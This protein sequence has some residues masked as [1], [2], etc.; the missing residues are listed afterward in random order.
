MTKQHSNLMKLLVA[1]CL[2]LLFFSCRLWGEQ[3]TIPDSERIFIFEHPTNLREPDAK[4]VR[5]KDEKRANGGNLVFVA[6]MPKSWNPKSDKEARSSGKPSARGIIAFSSHDTKEEIIREMTKKAGYQYLIDLADKYNLAVV[7]WSYIGGYDNEKNYDE[8][9]KNEFAKNSKRFDAIANEW[10]KGYRRFLS[11][12]NLPK[13]DAML[14]GVSAGA[15]VAHRIAMRKPQ[16]FSGIFI[17]VNS[18]YDAPAKEASKLLWCV[19]TGEYEYGYSSA[20]RFYKKALDLG[21]CAI[22]KPFENTGHFVTDDVKELCAAFFEY[23]ITFIADYTNPD[24]KEPPVDKYYLM[25]Y[26]AYI[27]DYQNQIAYPFEAAERKIPERKY[28]VSLPTKKIAQA[29]GEII[30]E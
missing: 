6:R 26:P 3:N 30:E 8:I 24:W 27:G 25:K 7:S 2:V 21:Y 9:E 11:L 19:S 5:G 14:Y 22:F 20:E 29:W 13:K 17:H 12:Y 18:S 1:H 16:Y 10:E 4:K 28:M 15:Q 23:L